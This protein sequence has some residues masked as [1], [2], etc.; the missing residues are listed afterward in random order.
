M[1]VLVIYES[2]F[3]NTK[4]IA[5]AIGDGLSGW[6]D[7]TVVDVA[8]APTE[9]PADVDIAIVGGPTHAFSMSRA[10]TRR[11]AAHRGGAHTDVPFGIRE[12]LEAQ[13]KG[14][15]EQMFAAFDTRVHVP[16]LPGAASRSATRLAERRGFSTME[17]ESFLV[18][19]YEGPLVPGE[20]ERA[21]QWGTRLAQVLAEWGA[22][23]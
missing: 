8:D 5:Q 2:M 7:A 16:L 9:I 22:T 21:A 10:G 23:R 11:D 14:R 19:G 4:R 6:A 15:H 18:E 3:G 1:R 12:W 20:V 17:P 13:P